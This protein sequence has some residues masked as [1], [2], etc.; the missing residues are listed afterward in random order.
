MTT[1][2]ILG[3]IEVQP[4]ALLATAPAEATAEQL[5][6]ALAPHRLCLPVFPLAPGATLAELV[7]RNAGGRRALRYGPVG[8]HLR[9]AAIESP[10]SG[11]GGAIFVAGGPTIKRATGYGLNRAIAGGDLGLGAPRELTFSLRP[12]PEARAATLLRCRDL[13]AACALGAGLLAAGLALS[14]L[15]VAE[16]AGGAGLLLAELEGAAAVVARQGPELARLAAEA[17]VAPLAEAEP[18]LRWERLAAEHEAAGALVASLTL[19]RAALPAFVARA[20]AAAARYGAALRVWGDAGVGTLHLAVAAEGREA[21]AAQL[22][23]VLGALAAEYGGRRSTEL[24][25]AAPAPLPAVR[26]PA[27]AHAEPGALLAALRDIVGPGFLLTRQED[28]ATYE[29][30]ASIAKPLGDALAVALPADTEQVAALVRLAAAH[31]I[32]VVTRGAGSG[33][34]GGATPSA[35][36]LVISLNRLEQIKVDAAQMT[37]QVG[38]GAI[39]SEVQRAAEAAGLFYP[40]DPSSQAAS[41]IGGNVACNAGGPRCVKYGV[42][43]DYV[44]AVTAVLADGSIVRWGDGLAGQA[45]DSALAQLMVGSEGTL[46]VITDAT[47]R[48]IPAPK[49]R[50]TTMALFDSLEAACATVERIMAGGV[51]PAGL[52]LMDD[53]CIA[54]VEAYLGLGLPRDA[55]AMLLLLAD[56][57]PEEVEADAARL[58]DF[59]RAGGARSVQVAQSA[60]DEA[61]LWKARRA[62]SIALTRVRPNRLGEDISVPLPRIAECVRRIKQVSAEHGLPIVVF[63]HAGDG[64][65]HPNILFD[66]RDPAEAARIWPAAEAVFGAALAVGGTLSGEHGV[67]TLKRPFMRQALGDGA[68]AAQRAIKARLDPAGILN[69]GKVLP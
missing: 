20:R 11:P 27:P 39:T 42:T 19:P 18:W 53:S 7:A 13:G 57:E 37:A 52:E 35:G 15:A 8:R 44:L 54:A 22:L 56:G 34:A 36:A 32:P 24:G 49:T 67:G 68:L 25:G 69:P 12:L 63:G 46:G 47:L 21:E 33:L 51:V 14:A 58:A 41:T 29:T 55:G 65:L 48:L 5:N 40:P 26:P 50:R 1:T 38:A 43:A 61:N 60:A 9:A 4:G 66:G 10:E 23:A 31:C 2:D 28:V 16:D 30:D 64:N 6:A 59:A 62:V 17:G 3:A 45:P